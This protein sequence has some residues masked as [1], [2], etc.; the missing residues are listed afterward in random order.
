[1]A[2]EHAQGRPL[3]EAPVW[4]WGSAGLFFVC[5]QCWCWSVE[6]ASVND[7]RHSTE[8]GGGVLVELLLWSSFTQIILLIVAFSL[9]QAKIIHSG[10]PIDAVHEQEQL[11]QQLNC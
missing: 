3:K 2:V 8:G 9:L 4:G 11:N 5:H 6:G 7:A 1:M 10:V